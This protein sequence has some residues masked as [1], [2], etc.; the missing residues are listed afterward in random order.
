VPS[1]FLMSEALAISMVIS[2][3]YRA[4]LSLDFLHS[5]TDVY[6]I[7]WR[8]FYALHVRVRVGASPLAKSL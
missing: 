3:L 6:K 1:D 7:H 5:P 2:T 4:S 8:L